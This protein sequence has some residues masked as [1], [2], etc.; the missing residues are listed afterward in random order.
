[1]LPTHII[2]T[3]WS[4]TPY[5]MRDRST[6]HSLQN[7]SFDDFS[8]L[9]SF[10]CLSKTITNKESGRRGEEERGLGV[11]LDQED[12]AK[13]NTLGVSTT[14]RYSSGFPSACAG[15]HATRTPA[16]MP[17]K[18]A[19]LPLSLATCVCFCECTCL[20]GCAAKLALGPC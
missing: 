6:T 13:K 15:M 10:G 4:Y 3:M 5:S 12:H 9:H 18:N 1:M 16:G 17:P 2:Y 11:R 8:I 14:L 19:T 7:M 20:A